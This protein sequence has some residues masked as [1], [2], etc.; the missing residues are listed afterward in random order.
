MLCWSQRRSGVENASVTALSDRFFNPA[1][2]DQGLIR[3]LLQ[4]QIAMTIA[5]SLADNNRE[6]RH[7]T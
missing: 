5:I 3:Y 1:L 4:T 7:L 6:C 2:F